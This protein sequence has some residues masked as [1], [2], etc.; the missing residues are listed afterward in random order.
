MAIE[1]ITIASAQAG[2]GDPLP[3]AAAAVPSL[4]P[5]ELE[6]DLLYPVRLERRVDLQIARSIGRGDAVCAVGPGGC[7]DIGAVVGIENKVP[8][9]GVRRGVDRMCDVVGG[10]I[11][12]ELVV[13]AKFH[14]LG[15]LY[16]RIATITPRTTLTGGPSRGWIPGSE[17]RHGGLDA[18]TG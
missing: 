16:D 5:E 2:S 1:P 3:V 17:V 7:V 18:S 10:R 12:C 14:R 13:D 11:G 8:V 15:L 9:L 4:A 6:Q